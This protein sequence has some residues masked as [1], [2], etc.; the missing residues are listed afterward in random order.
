MAA[1]VLR[2]PD[3]PLPG[4]RSARL[5]IFPGSATPTVFPARTPFWI[6]YGFTAEPEDPASEQ[7]EISPET[8]FE[9]IVDGDPVQ[10]L[11]GSRAAAGRTVGRQFMAVFE[12]GLGPGWHRFEGRWYDAGALALS[13][14]M[15]I[16]FVEP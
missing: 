8:T 12:Q 6:G 2:P 5:D 3:P 14:E 9:L 1:L 16:E 7:E 15:R 11:V 10:L 13:G 4:Q